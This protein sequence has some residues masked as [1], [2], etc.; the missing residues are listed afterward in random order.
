MT[1]RIEENF[2]AMRANLKERNAMMAAIYLSSDTKLLC[3]IKKEEIQSSR[4]QDT[5]F[6][7]HYKLCIQ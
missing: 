1:R 4:L 3:H 5:N 2:K 7:R 6:A